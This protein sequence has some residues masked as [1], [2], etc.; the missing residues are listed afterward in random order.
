MGGGALGRWRDCAGL[1]WLRLLFEG[2]FICYFRRLERLLLGRLK[3]AL[4]KAD[5]SICSATM[6]CNSTVV[7]G[8]KFWHRLDSV[9]KSPF[10]HGAGA[11]C[12]HSGWHCL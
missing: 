1:A 4:G 7:K 6:R 12:P 2:L 8:T 10:P 11:F 3:N 5:Q 9:R